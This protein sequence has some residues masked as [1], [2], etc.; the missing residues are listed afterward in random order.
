MKVLRPG[1]VALVIAILALAGC[2]GAGTA[3]GTPN[4]HGTAAPSQPFVPP[5]PTAGASVARPTA[6]PSRATLEPHSL[7][8]ELVG[9]WLQENRAGMTTGYF[10]RTLYVFAADG[11]YGLYVL[12]CLTGSTCSDADP[13]EGGLAAVDGRVLSLSPQTASVEGPRSYTFAV[14][15]DPNM[16]DLRLQF[17]MPDYVDEFFWAP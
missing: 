1:S 5:L 12:L 14:V 11:R 4:A 10:T 15:R 13:P 3:I 16:G 8:A 17:F 7:P 2:A 6:T 9:T